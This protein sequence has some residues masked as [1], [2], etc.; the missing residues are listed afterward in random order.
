MSKPKSRTKPKTKSKTKLKIKSKTKWWRDKFNLFT[1]GFTYIITF[2]IF[3]TIMTV[4]FKGLPSIKEALLTKEIQFSIKLSLYTSII[5]T[6]CCILISIPIA[7]VLARVDVQGKQFLNILLDLPLALPPVVS[8]VCLLL[9][10]G[11]TSFGAWL[12]DI[13]FGFVFTVKGVIISQIFVNLSFMIRVLKSTILAIN[14]RLDFIAR[15]LGCTPIQTFLKVTLPLSKNGII[16]G[17]V[18]TWARAL[19]EFGAALMLAGATRLR[20]ETLPIS[21]FLN[22]ST[23]DMDAAMA[24]ANILIIIS[25]ISLFVFNKY[26]GDFIGGSRVN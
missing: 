13:G 4:I 25:V 3:V 2:C 23:G 6:V 11:T 17:T 14:P 24:A 15:T 8:G 22:M 19:G 9:I 5:S 16:A 18:I 20:T 26:G 21:L 12:E 10:F 1:V 7:Y